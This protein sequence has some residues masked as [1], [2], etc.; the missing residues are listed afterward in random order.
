MKR[1]LARELRADWEWAFE[2][3]QVV[4]GYSPDPAS[5]GR[6][7]LA[8]LSL[9]MLCLDA[10]E[11]G[12]AVWPGRAYQRFKDAS[13]MTE[14]QGALVALLFSGSPL[15]DSALDAFYAMFERTRSSSTSGSRCRR[16]RRSTATG[17][18]SASARCCA[19]RRSASPTRTVR[20]A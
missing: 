6:R 7:A 8:N 9:L 18:S 17:C 11:R 12:D 10:V 2:A 15:A 3:H 1:S 20:A 14:R 5:S 13:N 16:R 4:G 19:T